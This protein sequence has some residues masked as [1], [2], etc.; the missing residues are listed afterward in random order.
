MSCA[1]VETAAHGGFQAACRVEDQ[2]G[3]EKLRWRLF[4]SGQD[5]RSRAHAEATV[6]GHAA[7][8]W[9]HND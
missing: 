2:N 4:A 7:V 5:A 9:E 8:R 6:R 1:L 3:G